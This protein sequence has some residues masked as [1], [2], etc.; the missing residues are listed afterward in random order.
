[1]ERIPALT[2]KQFKEADRVVGHSGPLQG[3]GEGAGHE[4]GLMIEGGESIIANH[5]RVGG[6]VGIEQLEGEEHSTTLASRFG[7]VERERFEPGES[8]LVALGTT[9]EGSAKEKLI[10]A[11]FPAFL[12]FEE[13]PEERIT[14]TALLI[15]GDK[16]ILVRKVRATVDGRVAR[17]G[18]GL[19]AELAESFDV[20]I[21]EEKTGVLFVE[22]VCSQARR[23]GELAGVDLLQDGEGG[24]RVER[25]EGGIEEPLERSIIPI[26]L[27]RVVPVDGDGF[28]VKGVSLQRFGQFDATVGMGESP[29]K[30]EN[31]SVALRRVHPLEKEK[32]TI[33][34]KLFELGC[35]LRVI[36]KNGGDT[37]HRFHKRG[38]GRRGEREAV[39]V[40]VKHLAHPL[41]ALALRV[42]D[43]DFVVAAWIDE[44][45][46]SVH[47]GA[48]FANDR[49]RIVGGE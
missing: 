23:R 41:P 1:M 36:R 20:P 4:S 3:S 24:N 28:A 7:D 38:R 12:H 48:K 39:G 33:D 27:D 22:V 10:V 37:A 17:A 46:L 13:K 14:V 25:F 40:I 35:D 9:E 16:G 47:E 19:A 30:S 34:L 32:L 11:R 45:N 31:G 15:K 18:D 49:D 42:A 26:T 6:G 43:L 29:L 2:A 44:L 5:C 21:E 8:F